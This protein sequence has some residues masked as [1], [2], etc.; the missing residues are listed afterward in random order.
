MCRFG[1]LFRYEQVSIVQ[2]LGCGITPDEVNMS[3]AEESYVSFIRRRFRET[4]RHV[5]WLL[6]QMTET[7]NAHHRI[8][9]NGKF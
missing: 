2:C 6:G 3:D 9:C 5:G 8:Q 1:G 4:R 7:Q